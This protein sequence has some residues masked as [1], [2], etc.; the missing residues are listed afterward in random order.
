MDPEVI[1][2]TNPRSIPTFS[3]AVGLG[4]VSFLERKV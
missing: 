2:K 1:R 3:K 4:K